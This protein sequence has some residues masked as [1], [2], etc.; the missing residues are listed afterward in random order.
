MEIF[1]D[2]PDGGSTEKID[3]TELEDKRLRTL[4]KFGS[5][6]AREE[7]KKRIGID[8]F[9]SLD[10]LTGE[11]A[12]FYMEWLKNNDSEKYNRIVNTNKD[13]E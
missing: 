10:E 8:P 12:D 13:S 3:V 5:S 9:K 7:I 11:D 2:G 6:E 1:V 4:A